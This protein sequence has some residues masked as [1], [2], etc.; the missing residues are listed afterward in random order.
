M[1]TIGRLAARFGEAGW[2]L[3]VVVVATFLNPFSEQVFEP[4]KIAL[5]RTIAILSVAAGAIAALERRAVAADG[6]Q[7][8]REVA[9]RAITLPVDR[10]YRAVRET[11]MLLAVGLV[12]LSY[13]LSTVTSVAPRMSWWGSYER[14]EGTYS[15]LTYLGLFSVAVTLLRR[16]AQ[17]ERTITVLLIASVPVAL[18]AVFQRFGATL[19]QFSQAGIETRVISTQGNAIFLAAYLAMLVP[20]T[21]WRLLGVFERRDDAPLPVPDGLVYSALLILQLAAILFT[22]SRG[23]MLAL[24]A[25]GFVLLLLVAVLL[26]R[27]WAIAGV[28]VVTLLIVLTAVVSIGAIE[29]PIARELPY[30]ARFTGMLRSSEAQSR[31][32]AWATTLEAVSESPSRVLL[33]YGPETMKPILTRY[34]PAQLWVLQGGGRYGTFDRAHN[35][36]FDALYAR[37][38]L[39][40]LAYLV[41]YAVIFYQSLRWLGLIADRRAAVTFGA[42]VGS[43]AVAGLVG[44]WAWRGD[45]VL[46]GALVPAGM[47]AGLVLYL[48]VQLL[49][50]PEA[51]P[52]VGRRRLLIAALLAAVVGHFVET[53]TGIAIAATQTYLW[54]YLA[55]LFVVG[56]GRLAAPARLAT[57]RPP[58]VATARTRRGRRVRRRAPDVQPWP[59]TLGPLIALGLVVAFMLGTLA[60]AFVHGFNVPGSRWPA[61]ILMWLTWLCAGAVVLANRRRLGP[62]DTALLDDS[63]QFAASSLAWLL[64]FVVF[65]RLNAR[66]L[67][68][69]DTI[70]LV[71]VLWMSLTFIGV[72]VALYRR[73][74]PSASPVGLRHALYAA[75]VLLALTMAWQADLQR[76]R[77]D[78][79]EKVA[80]TSMGAGLSDQALTYLER[81]VAAQPHQDQYYIFLGGAYVERARVTDDRTQRQSWMQRAEQVLAQGQALAPRNSDHPRQLGLM[82]TTWADWAVDEATRQQRLDRA[83]SY[84]Q[85]ALDLDPHNPDLHLGL[86]DVY[87]ALERAAAA[88]DAYRQAI[89][90]GAP[91]HLARAYAGVGDALLMA[92]E[93]QPAARAYRSAMQAGQDSQEM[94]QARARAVTSAPES[95]VRRER[96]ALAY[97]A[98]DRL[99]EAREELNVALEIASA[100][101]ER[102]QVTE[103]IGLIGE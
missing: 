84:Y 95:V 9:R 59:A 31:L 39:G 51:A 24:L 98:A 23:P 97:A 67:E 68:Q 3:A 22:Q 96:L 79:H 71:F 10:A 19:L 61:Q 8:A 11:P 53:Q 80:K 64:P 45:L 13:L 21:A 99:N 77:A 55:L 25:E 30:L 90:I 78:I 56:T 66:A 29:R 89:E 50:R 83:L 35:A 52:K 81:A 33:G 5:L 48:G 91:T 69:L 41:L 43:G 93:L 92:G 88:E 7:S 72:A 46:A 37:G 49:R 103:L 6:R 32:L 58:P 60:Y 16:R 65:H 86:G 28:A 73:P 14:A 87:L 76:V 102:A 1:T 85:D 27:R 57:N 20:L 63:L 15:F 36:V 82:Y 38:V 70:Y 101:G 62:G 12:L 47:L 34:M 75:I 44:A 2:L 40:V 17:L 100:D 42:L 94:L 4:D 18:Y 26:R 74:A 54:L